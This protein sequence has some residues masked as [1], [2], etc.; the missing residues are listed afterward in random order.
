MAVG[1]LFPATGLGKTKPSHMNPSDNPAPPADPDE[2]H[3]ITVL[4]NLYLEIGL[5]LQA[6][7]QSAIADY[8]S[9]FEEDDSCQLCAI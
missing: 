1:F 2:R 6:A 3:P 9:I 4:S 5:P 8:E 7:A